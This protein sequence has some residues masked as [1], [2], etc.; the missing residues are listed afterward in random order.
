MTNNSSV[1]ELSSREKFDQAAKLIETRRSIVFY[2]QDLSGG[3]VE[4][5][6]LSLIEELRTW[7]IDVTLIV[8]SATGPLKQLLSP[9]LPLIEIGRS[10]TILS[11]IPLARIL[12]K[13]KPDMLVASLDHNNIAALLSKAISFSS[14]PIVI[15]QHNAL[16]LEVGLGWK[17]Q[18]V[19]FAYRHLSRFAAAVVAVS[20]GVA[21]DLAI[22]CNILRSEITTI[23][24]PVIGQDF[25]LRA[26]QP[27]LHS[28][29]LKRDAPVF[30][31]V[32][33]LIAQKNP[34][35]VLQAFAD[36]VVHTAARLVFIGDGPLRA[37]LQEQ[38]ES[39]GLSAL[40]DFAGFQSNPLPWINLADALILTSDYE[41]FGNVIVEAL[42][43]GTPVVATDCHW[44][45]SEI[46][47]NGRYGLLVPCGDVAA[48]SL[49]LKSVLQTQWN[50]EKLRERG[51][52]FSASA[53]AAAHLSLLERVGRT[54][55][56]SRRSGV[57]LGLPLARATAREAAN[58]L[59]KNHPH[60]VQ[61]VVTPNLDHL[62]LLRR[63]DFAAAY[64]WAHLCFAD[65]FPLVAYARLRGLK[66]RTRVTGCEIFH[67]IAN[68]PDLGEQLL[69]VVV[70]SETS[71]VAV[72]AWA[73]RLGMSEQIHCE[74]A[75]D[76]LLGSP[77][78]QITLARLAANFRPTILVMTLGA[79][80]SEI[81]VYRNREA[82]PPCWA[83]CIGQAVRVELGLTK[84]APLLWQ[85]LN[86]E[87]LWRLRQEPKRLTKRYAKAVAWFPIAIIQDKLKR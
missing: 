72:N 27:V 61:L 35:L 11:V 39:L 6:R 74:V 12:R 26:S 19:P 3:G 69:F 57:V 58:F 24:N 44:G 1:V 85:K 13:Q 65:G 87:W 55:K 40:V 84:R 64:Q 37:A 46:L 67:Q 54:K 31:F 28:W 15:C 83:I 10:R 45:P 56:S 36:L 23:Y 68:H 17:Y 18:I 82:L 80:V 16:S 53:C 9:D 32:G 71:C 50:K 79:P 43:L 20:N 29:F 25:D 22:T 59:F 8:G 86:L 66:L 41:G 42:A 38:A 78:A 49:A 4:R 47:E 81:F 73:G 14:C 60:S 62:Q 75:V 5:M 70:E 63:P 7:G 34:E 77:S 30:V 76:G 2:M 21:D 52:M 48:T 51:R 33:R